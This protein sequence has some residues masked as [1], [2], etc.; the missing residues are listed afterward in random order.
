M[1]QFVVVDLS[2]QAAFLPPSVLNPPDRFLRWLRQYG[3]VGR[4]VVHKAGRSV[5]AYAFR[6][7]SGLEA[8]FWYDEQ[9]DLHVDHDDEVIRRVFIRQGLLFRNVYLSMRTQ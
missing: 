1:K 7:V 6:S 2:T 3:E 5:E 9:G 8:S 4:W